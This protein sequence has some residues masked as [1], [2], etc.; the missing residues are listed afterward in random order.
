MSD[1]ERQAHDEL[2]K[3]YFDELVEFFKRPIPE[4]VQKRTRAIVEAAK[5]NESSR[6]LDVGTGVG[7][8][9]DHILNSGVP[10]SNIVGCDLSVRMLAEARVRYPGVKFWQ[11]DFLDLPAEYGPFNTVLI[12]ACFGN[13]LDQSAVIARAAQFLA[14]GGRIVISHPMG[15][16]FVEALHASEPEIVPHPLPERETLASWALSFALA[17]ELFRNDQ[18]LY[19]AILRRPA[20]DLS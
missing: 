5:L 17:L 8:L 11:G 14:P 15:N 12:N 6:V 1:Q 7:V 16:R 18:D 3:A 4:Q 10:H 2:E 20:E 9:I 19:I 13:F